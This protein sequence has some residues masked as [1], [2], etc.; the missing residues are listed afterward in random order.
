M[1]YKQDI[2]LRSSISMQLL[3]NDD[4]THWLV[5]FGW[6]VNN[7]NYS[8]HL[9]GLSLANDG[10]VCHFKDTQSITGIL[11]YGKAALNVS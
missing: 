5:P 7:Q 10:P 11:T 4:C 8:Q 9:F 3:I 1:A 2:D 6:Y